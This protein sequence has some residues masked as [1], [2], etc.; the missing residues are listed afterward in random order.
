[1]KKIIG[2]LLI[3]FMTLS[4][5]A[6][7]SWQ[8]YAT[9]LHSEDYLQLVSSQSKRYAQSVILSIPTPSS[10]QEIAIYNAAHDVLSA[11]WDSPIIMRIA[12]FITN[13]TYLT[14][15]SDWQAIGEDINTALGNSCGSYT[16]F[17]CISG[18]Y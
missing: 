15:L 8:V 16:V 7:P 6:A 2:I 10:A 18:I 9:L 1:M 13:D 3:A 4:V 12:G 17:A 14:N 5:N 11:K